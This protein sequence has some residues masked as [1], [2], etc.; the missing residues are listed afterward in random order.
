[1]FKNSII[2]SWG[3]K[4]KDKFKIK[5]SFFVISFSKGWGQTLSIKEWRQVNKVDY[6]ERRKVAWN[7]LGGLNMVVGREEKIGG[8]KKRNIGMDWWIRKGED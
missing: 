1:M 6:V 7:Y 8:K 3:Y 4:L 2:K 5:N